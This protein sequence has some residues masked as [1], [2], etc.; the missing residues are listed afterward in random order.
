MG[1]NK[2]LVSVIVPIYNGEKVIRRCIESILNQD[3]QNIE[4]LLMDDGS[5]DGSP[6]I[7]DE[8]AAA[9][10]RVRVV[11]KANSGVSDTRN[12]AL[13]LA[14]G[15]Y[16]QF[17][18]ADDWIVPEATRL[19]V[20]SME[21]NDVDMVVADF[22][23]VVGENTSRKGSIDKGGVYTKLE[24]AD[25]MLVS[26]A[27]YYYGVIW[28]KL[29]K[30][31]IIEKNQLAM[32]ENINW[33]EDFIFNMEYILHTENIYILKVPVYYYVKTEGSLVSQGMNPSKIVRMK[34]NVIEY[35]R[36][37]YKNLL[38][39]EEYEER[40]PEIY[41]FL[42]GFA[43]DDGA[44]SFLPGTKKLGKERPISVQETDEVNLWTSYYYMKK[45]IERE[46]DNVRLEFNLSKREL[47]ILTYLHMFG[48]IESKEELMDY[49]D[50]SWPVI[51]SVLEQLYFKDYVK[52]D[53][54]RPSTAVLADENDEVFRV[55]DRALEDL[56]AGLIEDLPGESGD[57]FKK[58][59]TKL[60]KKLSEMSRR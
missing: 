24:Y 25:C 16:I 9:D 45:M 57:S 12:Q 27:D 11:H 52:L 40:K 46:M 5:K 47:R 54:G 48:S 22:Y 29:F 7:C 56:E 2:A 10:S 4:L 58:F 20:R 17:L 36:N 32:D 35:Y 31:D 19:F 49:M 30:R 14:K 21:D 3:Y 23:R 41:S 39:E 44:F 42:L 8:Y 50:D 51:M 18:D 37:F 34:L 6:A 38:T 15:D 33:C 55:L 53:M 26:P 60:N 28:N 43:H 1:E 59:Q 13:S